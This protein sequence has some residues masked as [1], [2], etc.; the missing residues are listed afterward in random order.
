MG[1]L[2]ALEA[3][4][5]I[6]KLRGG[7]NQQALPQEEAQPDRGAPG[8]ST[9]VQTCKSTATCGTPQVRLASLLVDVMGD[10]DQ[11]MGASGLTPGQKA[12]YELCKQDL[13]KSCSEYEKD[14]TI[15][16]GQQLLS[17]LKRLEKVLHKHLA[18]QGEHTSLPTNVYVIAQALTSILSNPRNMCFGNSAFRCWSWTGAHAEDQRGDEL[19]QR[20]DSSYLTPDPPVCKGWIRCS[21]SARTFKRAVKLTW[22][23]SLATYGALLEEPSLEASSFTFISMGGKRKESKLR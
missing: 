9:S 14:W 22:E 19:T 2:W 8:S 13:M 3:R 5:G 12:L 7:A 11:S 10:E 18:V 15:S 16:K 1:K 21:T 4:A 17:D 20:F 23:T 6:F